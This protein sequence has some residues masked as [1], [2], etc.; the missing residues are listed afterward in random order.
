VKFGW[1][2]GWSVSSVDFGCLVVQGLVGCC[3]GLVDG[4]VGG[5]VGWCVGRLERLVGR[6]VG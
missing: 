2:V 1:W 4:L 3:V 6:W 5:L